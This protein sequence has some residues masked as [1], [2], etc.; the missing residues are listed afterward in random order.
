[1]SNSNDQRLEPI[2]SENLR[3]IKY[4]V[5]TKRS[6]CLKVAYLM[7]VKCDHENIRSS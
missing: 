5:H 7:C 2:V 6:E 1:M 3:K 4:A